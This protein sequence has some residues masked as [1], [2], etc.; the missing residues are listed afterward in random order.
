M[1]LDNEFKEP[2]IIN[3]ID[4]I[5]DSQLVNFTIVNND[6]CQKCQKF[7]ISFNDLCSYCHKG[8]NYCIKC[9]NFSEQ[10]VNQSYQGININDK[11][12]YIHAIAPFIFDVWNMSNNHNELTCYYKD[13]GDLKTCPK[14]LAELCN[15]WDR[16]FFSTFTFQSV[17]N[18]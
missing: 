17:S 12:R 6:L 3:N 11:Y 10:L 2:V 15:L 14:S 5:N 18:V 1:Q 9:N 4:N 13:M 7:S 16:A 8:I